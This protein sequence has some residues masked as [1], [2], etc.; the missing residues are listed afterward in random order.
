[1]VGNQTR[2]MVVNGREITLP[3]EPVIWDTFDEICRRES[4]DSQTLA[5]RIDQRRGARDL[6]SIIRVFVVSYVRTA[7]EAERRRRRGFGEEID[8]DQAFRHALDACG[9]STD[10]PAAAPDVAT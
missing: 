4:C 5:G 9:P 2:T 7:D 8:I 6:A 10:I 1:M 3:L